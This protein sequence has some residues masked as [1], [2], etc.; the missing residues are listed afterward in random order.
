MTGIEPP[1][2]T[3]RVRRWIE[4]LRELGVRLPEA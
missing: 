4:R 2:I 3:V 1:V